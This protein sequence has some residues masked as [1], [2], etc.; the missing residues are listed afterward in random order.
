M[1]SF[2]E[3]KLSARA[4]NTVDLG[5]RH[6]DLQGL[7]SA[8]LQESV[9]AGHKVDV[10]DAKLLGERAALEGS[11]GRGVLNHNFHGRAGSRCDGTFTAGR[12]GH[13]PGLGGKG[14][15][16]ATSSPIASQPRSFSYS[17]KM[18]RNAKCAFSVAMALGRARQA[19]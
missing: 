9:L 11:G 16:I 4:Q 6:T 19:A 12:E 5:G 1:Y 7:S 13:G 2:F 17:P 3:S 18:A 14:L 10:A 8:V 15:F